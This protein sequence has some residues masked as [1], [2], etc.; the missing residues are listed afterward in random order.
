M[1]DEI[2]FEAGVARVSHY[3]EDDGYC[4]ITLDVTENGAEVKAVGVVPEVREGDQ[5]RIQGVW[6]NHPVYG[7]QIKI[8]SAVRVMPKTTTGLINYLSS[9]LIRGIGPTTAERIVSTFG[10]GTVEM[11]DYKPDMLLGIKGI[12]KTKLVKIIEDWQNNRSITKTM[13]FLQGHGI[14]PGLAY[15]LHKVYGEDTIDRVKANP[16]ELAGRVWGVGFQTADRIARA[17]E[18]PLY[19]PSRIEAGVTYVLRQASGEGHTMLPVQQLIAE[20]TKELGIDS[21]LVESAIEKLIHDG[22]CVRDTGEEGPSIYLSTFYYTEVGAAAHLQRL[23]QDP[24]SRF[25]ATLEKNLLDLDTKG[26]GLGLT[27]TQIEAVQNALINKVTLLAGGPG[28][29]KTTCLKVLVDICKK[30]WHPIALAS[31][32]GRA[33]KR[34]AEATGEEAQTIHRL[35]GFIP[36]ESGFAHNEQ[37]PL[38]VD[39]L[40]V[41]ESSMLDINIT[42]A[43]LRAIPSDTHVLF[44]GD[45]DQLPAVGAGNVLQ[46]MINSQKICLTKL[47]KVFRQGK[48]SLIIE[49][50]H[51]I[52]NGEMPDVTN[53]LD[54][55]F[56]FFQI[57]DPEKACD[58]IVD[59]VTKRLPERYGFDPTT[60]IQV[61]AP[62]R[63]GVLG[64]TELNKRLRNALNPDGQ[65]KA[66]IHIGE[67]TFRVGDKVM[68]LHNNY[69]LGVFNGDIGVI[70]HINMEDSEIIVDFEGHKAVYDTT[71]LD[72]LVH[73]YCISY[74]KSQGGEVPVVITVIHESHY[75]MLRRNLIYTGITRGKK[76]CII[77]GTKKA[78]QMAVS[79]NMVSRRHTGL[80]YRIGTTAPAV[81]NPSKDESVQPNLNFFDEI[82]PL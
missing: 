41:D 65:G 4:V 69:A 23:L 77:I 79:N 67:R 22:E 73:A 53:D 29:G 31:P 40:I 68:Q 14:T 49:N 74:H 38:D 48:G 34:M 59:L 36:G 5:L 61:L 13:T 11:L 27:G 17:M 6:A 51:R 8:N 75:V 20:S 12:S 72:D 9:G 82:D 1:S 24:A 42:Y 32:T 63:R 7:R 64:I 66:D 54:G 50:A 2:E 21:V 19:A 46:D 28:S 76:L 35:L 60:D 10:E 37:E 15:K 57:G 26:K 62:M 33:A 3:N 44:V 30:S 16:Y 78:L 25:S 43:L 71:E 70:E 81:I 45:P 18:I 80:A 58:Q 52:N 56:F 47:T 39:L 55:D